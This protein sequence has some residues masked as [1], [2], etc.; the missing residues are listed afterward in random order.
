[1]Q[2]RSTE[3]AMATSDGATAVTRPVRRRAG[4][5]SA[6][7]ALAVSGLA[8]AI[9]PTAGALPSDDS[10]DS[11]VAAAG[12]DLADLDTRAGQARE[13]LSA[14]E[15]ALPGAQAESAA[16]QTALAAAQQV[17][18]VAAAALAAA[19]AKVAQTKSRIE[20]LRV[21]IDE[22]KAA[23]ADFARQVYA[24]GGDVGELGI[25]LDS[26]DPGDLT[27]RLQSITTVSRGKNHD[28]AKFV[29]AKEELDTA[30][31]SLQE[32]EQQAQVKR[33]EAAA[34]VAAAEE[35]AARAS[36]AERRVA[37]LV[38]AR[39]SAVA[40]VEARRGVVQQRFDQLKATQDA[41]A[42]K[43]AAQ[44]AARQRQLAA[45]EQAAS[46]QSTASDA[47]DSAGE[48]ESEQAPEEVEQAPAEPESVEAA[49]AG[50]GSWVF[51]TAGSVVGNV[52]PRI[53]PYTGS[54]GCHTGADIAAGMGTPIV[55]ARGGTVV[56]VQGDDGNAYGNNVVIDHGDG[57]SSMSAHMSSMAVSGGETVS[58]G[59]VIG[60]VGSTGWST[61]P[62]LHFEIHVGGV[63]YDPM[64]WLGGGS[65]VPAC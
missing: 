3:T 4:L 64:G 46:G 2:R 15:A 17:Q 26:E 24:T 28:V 22:L 36:E 58:A 18:E 33:D 63:P 31:V 60:Y 23:L 8:L 57:L 37:D 59:Q 50:D 53:N 34:A 62:H 49:P 1:M 32:L 16:A 9:A 56:S 27:E 6:L 40:E 47:G 38:A 12:D 21:Q 13:N 20:A 5:T 25:L 44:E 54:A 43:L 65:R 42:A 55:A 19:E 10:L 39:Q 35:A 14:A 41:L 29:A 45:A 61:G 7:A 51:P 48:A 30:L 52:G 11:Q